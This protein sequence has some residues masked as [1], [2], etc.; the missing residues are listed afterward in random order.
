MT[1]QTTAQ[2]PGIDELL[3]RVAQIRPIIERN[4]PEAEPERRIPEE[5][6]QALVDAGLFKITVPRRFGGYEVPIWTKMQVSA[7]VA[8]CD[9][10][11]AWVLTLIN[12][13]NWVGGVFSDACQ[14][15]IWGENPGAR[16]AGVLNP[17]PDVRRVE[18]GYEVSGRWPYASGS[19]HS[20]WALIGIVIPDENGEVVDQALA[21]APM[22]D[23]TIEDT[24]FVAG[25]KG[26]GSNTFVAENIFVPE[27]RTISMAKA[28]QNEY[29]TPHTDEVAYRASFIP[30][31]TLVLG[32]PQLGMG[33]AALDFVV[34]KAGRRGITYSFFERQADSAAFQIAIAKAATLIDSA[35][36]HMQRGAADVQRA[37]EAGE[38][39]PV[40]ARARVKQDTAFGV[41]RVREAIDGL[42]SAHGAASFAE[43]SPLQ[44]IWRDSATAGRHA[45]IDPAV[46]LEVYGRALLGVEE[47][48]TGLL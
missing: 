41:A 1:V 48:I 46:N 35:R 25:M 22:S 9:G 29:A 12:V 13:C 45:V 34:S 7:A 40:L 5:S 33:R 20:D 31:L 43:V 16:I 37:A 24:W 17:S 3:D 23:L 27:H 32:A 38:P 26:T 11:T 44:R 30:V 15:D 6:I 2:A 39:L 8:E 14:Q 18:G 36:L 19:L 47:Q 4:G 42:L 10:A 21:M 28:L